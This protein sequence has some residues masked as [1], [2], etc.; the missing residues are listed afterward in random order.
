MNGTPDP[1]FDPRLPPDPELAALQRALQPLRTA[2]PPFD[3]RWVPAAPVVVPR[4]RFVRWLAA[5][6]LA[7]AVGAAF[8]WAGGDA[9]RPSSSARQFA[10]GTAPLRVPLGELADV[11]LRPHS[12]LQFAHWRGDEA[13]FRLV[14]G[15]IDVRVAPPPQVPAGF[16]VVDTALGTVVDQGCRYSLELSSQGGAHVVVTE[17][18]VTFVRG[19]RTVFV[20]VGAEAVVFADGARTPCFQ[21]ASDELRKATAEYDATL[22]ANDRD[23]RGMAVKQVLAAAQ[24]D[25]DVLVLWHLLRDPEAMYRE[26]AEAALL[27]LVG[28]P[29]ANTKQ[30][31]FD[32]EEWLPFLRLRGWRP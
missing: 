18:A 31:T 30:E 27:D 4:R 24:Q 8:F 29:V 6:L 32:A 10:S 12:E 17:G 5:A 9:L 15:G 13:R 21:T 20:P 11:V 26:V 2:L 1:L 22:R 23:A 19:E 28:P 14:R 16:F 3:E 7:L 25:R